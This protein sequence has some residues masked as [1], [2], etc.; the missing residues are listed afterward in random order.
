LCLILFASGRS[1]HAQDCCPRVELF[2]GYSYLVSDTRSDQTT[3]R[4]FA[5]RVGA[6]GFG[7]NLAAN[8]SDNFALVGDLSYHALKGQS[9][10]SSLYLLAGPRFAARDQGVSFFGEALV[11]GRRANFDHSSLVPSHTDF[12]LGLG[13]GLEL[14][15]W[16]RVAVRLIQIDYL[17]T[18]NQGP[19][20][21]ARSGGW[22]H[23][24]RFET[25]VT[26][27]FG[28]VK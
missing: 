8:L 16:R 15:N 13:G 23:N 22:N 6:H 3:A 24:F 25:G 27:S 18:R 17:P 12:A 26:L 21:Q 20:A 7:L 14:G 11:G 9:K 4:P 2:G 1:A 5:T 19:A 28:L 10:S